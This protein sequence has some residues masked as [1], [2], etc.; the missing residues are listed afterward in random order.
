M[1]VAL[2]LAIPG[3]VEQ[4]TQ[5]SNGR[6]LKY[7]L[8]GTQ[9]CT[10]AAHD[11]DHVSHVS[12]SFW[13]FKSYVLCLQLMHTDCAGTKNLVVTMLAVAYFG[14]YSQTLKLSWVYDSFIPLLSAATLFSFALSAALYA[15]SLRRGALCA[16]GGCTGVLKICSASFQ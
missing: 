15:V 7:K 4:G 1:Q 10:P 16:K 6:K 8:T 12:K 9:S 13:S 2:H 5:L 14:F 3:P 11:V